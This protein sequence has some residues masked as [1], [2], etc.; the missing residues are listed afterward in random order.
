MQFEL[1]RHLVREVMLAKFTAW[2]LC[3]RV[4]SRAARQPLTPFPSHLEALTHPQPQVTAQFACYMVGSRSDPPDYV[5][6]SALILAVDLLLIVTSLLNIFV[7]AYTPDLYDVI[8]CYLISLSVADLLSAVIVIPLSVYSTLDVQWRIAGDN[9]YLCKGAAYAQI[10][11]FCST[12]YTFA[13]I[14]IDRYSAMMKPSRYSEQSLTRC[15]CWIV[16]SWLTSILLCCPIL[17]ARMQVIFYQDAQ[18]CVLDWTATSA[19]SMTL[20]ALVFL[21]TLVTV[22]NTGYKI[23][24]AM[25]N[26]DALDDIQRMVIETD[27]NF[28]LTIFLLVS[29]VLSWLPLL[30]LKIYEYLVIPQT[31]SDLSMVTFI[32]V[33]LAIAGPCCKFLIYMF[34]NSSFRKSLVSSLACTICC[35]SERQSRYDYHDIGNNSYL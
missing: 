15:K 5:A 14:C 32:F 9:S 27:P 31:D 12:V 19:Y 8:G 34:I 25:R 10:A 23:V 21:P 17:V 20:L 30:C 29:F 24:A 26:P 1:V 2:E 18:L 7:I 33:W 13:W 4:S 22:V 16:F 11:L 35:S 3:G 6:H 28:V